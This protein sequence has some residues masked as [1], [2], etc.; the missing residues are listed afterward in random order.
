MNINTPQLIVNCVND[1]D[2][3]KV[4]NRIEYSYCARNLVGKKTLPQHNLE[5]SSSPRGNNSFQLNFNG[6]FEDPKREEFGS[7]EM[8]S[9]N[10]YICSW[11]KN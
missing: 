1:G 10:E 7:N 2:Y 11:L 5:G 9:Q 8:Y 3:L 4:E 6:L